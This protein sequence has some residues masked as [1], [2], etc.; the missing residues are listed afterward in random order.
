MLFKNFIFISFVF[1]FSVQCTLKGNDSRANDIQLESRLRGAE[2]LVKN[3]LNRFSKIIQKNLSNNGLY[4]LEKELTFNKSGVLS[5]FNKTMKSNIYIT[6]EVKLDS[7]ILW[8][9]AVTDYL[10]IAWKD[11]KEKNNNLAWLYSFH[12]GSNTMRIFPWV[13]MSQVVGSSIKWSLVTFFESKDN[14]V[15]YKNKDICTRPYED[16]GGTG[17]NISCCSVITDENF[18]KNKTILSC[19]DLSLKDLIE[20]YS[21]NLL[22]N[23]NSLIKTI[24][25]ESFAPSIAYKKFMIVNFSTG[26]REYTDSYNTTNK[27]DLI[28]QSSYLNMKVYLEK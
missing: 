23:K 5:N 26:K 8:F 15:Q 9:G 18:N 19:V 14:L 25:I 16:L 20:E 13:D 22:K 28:A 17:A 3:T 6:K 1:L 24:V 10:E 2:D 7:N 11:E 27:L 21:N 12:V 4:N